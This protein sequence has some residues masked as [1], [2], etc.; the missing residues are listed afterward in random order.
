MKDIAD[1]F[2]F[3]DTGS[4]RFDAQ[5]HVSFFGDLCPAVDQGEAHACKSAN[6]ATPG[7][8]A[9]RCVVGRR[10]RVFIALP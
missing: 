5:P 4:A 8:F 10:S 1:K 3:T 2:A 9:V 7:R 6:P